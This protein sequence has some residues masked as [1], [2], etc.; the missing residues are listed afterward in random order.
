M[1]R[2]AWESYEG[3]YEK[4]LNIFET[5]CT[6]VAIFRPFRDSSVQS[7]GKTLVMLQPMVFPKI[8]PKRCEMVENEPSLF[9]HSNVLHHCA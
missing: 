1:A 5:R 2:A 3:E 7:L 6:T 4:R 8:V 9:S